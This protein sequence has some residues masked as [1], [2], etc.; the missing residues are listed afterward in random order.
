MSSKELA[1][2]LKRIQPPSEV[3]PVEE[4]PPMSAELSALLTRVDNRKWKN[5]ELVRTLHNLQALQQDIDL[6]KHV[7][8]C[9]QCQIELQL[10]IE[11]YAG[12]RGPWYLNLQNEIGWPEI[13]EEEGIYKDCPRP[14][15]YKIGSYWSGSSEDTIRF[16]KDRLTW[17]EKIIDEDIAALIDYYLLMEEWDLESPAPIDESIL[18]F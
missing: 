8:K 12:S 17:A 16:I 15:N 11:R 4:A 13:Y 6:I 18:I 3:K 7:R 9:G 14:Q 5:V 1:V 10:S 2:L